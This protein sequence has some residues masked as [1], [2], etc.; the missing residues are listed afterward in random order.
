MFS[1]HDCLRA[2]ASFQARWLIHEQ[3][4]RIPIESFRTALRL[5]LQNKVSDEETPSP[6]EVECLM[7]NMIHKGYI[8]GYISHERQMVVLSAKNAY[9]PLKERTTPFM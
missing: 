9:P 6:E 3:S 8:R 2:I 1:P 4:T 5:A 7:A